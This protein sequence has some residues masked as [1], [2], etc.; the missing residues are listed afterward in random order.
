MILLCAS[1]RDPT[2]L[3][4]GSCLDEIGCPYH[5]LDLDRYPQGYRLRLYWHGAELDGDLGSSDWQLELGEISSVYV[6]WPAVAELDPACVE[7]NTAL[8]LLLD[9]LP[10]LVVNRPR[11]GLSN[12]SKPYQASLIVAAGLLTPPTLVTNDPVAAAAFVAAQ[13]DGAIYKSLS[14]V[15][16]IVRRVGA[17][18]LARLPLLARSPSQFQSLL[19]GDNVRVH[20]VGRQVIA[21]QIATPSVDYRYAGRDGNAVTMQA[22]EL[23]PDVAAACLRLATALELPL[24]GID[25]LRTA[26]GQYYCFEANAMPAFAYFEHHSGQPISRA[27]AELLQR[28]TLAEKGVPMLALVFAAL[29]PASLKSILPY[30]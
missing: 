10:A 12:H 29:R 15:R 30:L 8:S 19:V 22:H 7:A 6:R 9:Q 24:V 11:L 17:A 21:T 26:D 2:A 3:L 23:P 14:S 27:L 4:V 5:W 1:P 16:S 20:V 18:Q 25:L 28:G 13:A